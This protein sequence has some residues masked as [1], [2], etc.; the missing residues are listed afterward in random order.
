MIQLRVELYYDK[1][2][3]KYPSPS[4]ISLQELLDELNKLELIGIQV[5]LKEKSSS[6]SNIQATEEEIRSIRPQK[7]GSIVASRGSVLPL[8]GSKKLNLQNTPVLLVRDGTK[9]VYVFP[10]K[11][12]ERYYGVLDGISFL[13]GLENELSDPKT[14]S[15]NLPELEGKME[16]ALVS[17]LERNPKLL[18]SDFELVYSEYETGTGKADLILKDSKGTQFVVE[19]ERTATDAAVGQVIRLTAGFEK[20]NPGTIAVP[21]IVCFRMNPNVQLAAQR[22]G[23][24]AWTYDEASGLFQKGA[25][26]TTTNVS[27]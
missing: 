6:S 26:L 23:I 1:T 12:G 10:C 18:G 5:L 20:K 9:P 8:S 13:R 16:Q 19:V 2:I 21:T 24:E 7:R 3:E 25:N 14:T 22:A 4:T 11:V 15:S 27:P 17:K